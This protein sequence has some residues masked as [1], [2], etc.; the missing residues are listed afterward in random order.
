MRMRY[1]LSVFTT[2]FIII[3]LYIKIKLRNHRV[4]CNWMKSE[5]RIDHWSLVQL[6]KNVVLYTVL[7]KTETS[8]SNSS[9]LSGDSSQAPKGSNLQASDSIK[10][11]ICLLFMVSNRDE[12][13][14]TLRASYPKHSWIYFL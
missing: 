5:K 3:L 9:C 10:A 6:E 7:S 2:D 4:N 8:C 1:K 13:C 11:S 12:Y 14:R